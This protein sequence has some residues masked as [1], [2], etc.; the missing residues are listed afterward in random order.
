MMWGQCRNGNSRIESKE[1]G[2]MPAW[3]KDN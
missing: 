2:G 1:P 3:N